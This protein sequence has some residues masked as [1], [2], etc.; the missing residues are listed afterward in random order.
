MKLQLKE[1]TC[2]DKEIFFIT[3]IYRT[4]VLYFAA[5]NKFSFGIERHVSR[6]N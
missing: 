5:R 3:Q 2:A 6:C 1:H 4:L